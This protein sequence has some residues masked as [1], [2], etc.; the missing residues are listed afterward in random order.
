MYALDKMDIFLI[1]TI[2]PFFI[3]AGFGYPFPLIV[4]LGCLYLKIK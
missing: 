2:I 3:L 1:S 4:S